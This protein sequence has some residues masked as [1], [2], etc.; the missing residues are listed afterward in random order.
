MR[1]LLLCLI[2]ILMLSIKSFAAE[3]SG[4][5]KSA[6]GQPLAQVFIFYGRS[7]NDIAESDSNGSFTLPHFG[8]VISFRRAGF[9]PLTKIVAPSTTKLDVILEDSAATEW[10]IPSCSNVKDA[11]KR[12]GYSLRLPVPKGVIARK[13]NDIDYSSFSIGYGAKENRVW[14]SGIE[15]PMASLG[16]PPEDWIL[17][18][19]E[20]TERSYKSGKAEGVDMRGRLADGTYWRYVGRLGESIEYNNLSREAAAFFDKIIDSACMRQ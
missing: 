18:A 11:G 17:N 16:V 14:L 4:T 12:V 2:A 19:Q 6:S 5:V 8:R 10:L 20:F 9:R 7:L 13:G 1:Y 3:L 15:G